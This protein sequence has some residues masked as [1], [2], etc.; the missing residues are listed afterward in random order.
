MNFSKIIVLVC[1]VLFSSASIACGHEDC[2]GSPRRPIIPPPVS[3][4]VSQ[5]AAPTTATTTT[6]K[7]N[8]N[9]ANLI[10][11]AILGV[12]GYVVY[13]LDKPRQTVEQ[14]EAGEKP[15]N[16]VSFG[17]QLQPTGE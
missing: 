12:C 10:G 15:E 4:P 5:P 16:R 2:D 8:D 13:S 6:H 17:V 1:V 3:P 14:V 7:S 11:L 9:F